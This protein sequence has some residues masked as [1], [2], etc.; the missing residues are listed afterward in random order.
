MRPRWFRLASIAWLGLNGSVLAQTAPFAAISGRV[1]D[2]SGAT[3]AGVRVAVTSPS[4]QGVREG[5][6]NATGDFLVPLLPP[7]EYE[8]GFRRDGFSETRLRLSLHATETSRVEVEL[9]IA[10]TA[11][12]L[13]VL[14]EPST[15]IGQAAATSSAYAA[16]L[17]DRLPVDRSPRGATLLAPGVAATA[18]GDNVTIAGAMSYENLYLVDGVSV[19]ERVLGQPRPFPIEDAL[20][21]TS[22]LVTGISAEYGR[23]TGGVVNV[24]TRSGGNE[25]NG[26]F[27]VSL[28]NEA[29][30]S[31]T[32]YEES[33]AE[34]PREDS[35]EPTYEGT[36]GGAFVRDR[37]WYFLAGRAQ[38]TTSAETLAFTDLP[39]RYRN[40]ESRLEA[41]L[42]LS[43]RPGQSLRLAYGEIDT[44]EVNFVLAPAMDFASLG[45]VSTPEDLLSLHYGAAVG[46]H[47]FLEG[48]YSR[49]RGAP[50]GRGSRETDLVGGTRLVDGS[51]GAAWNSPAFC[52]VC[53]AAPGE[54]RREEQSDRGFVAKATGL[55]SGTRTGSHTLVLG[56]EVF[57]E[58][59][60]SNSFQSGSGFVVTAS[61][62]RLEGGTIRPVFLPG[63]TT[64][65]EWRPIFELS[66]GSRFRTRSAFANDSWRFGERWSFNLGLRWDADDS[67]DQSGA[68]V[69]GSDLWSP[70]LAAAFDPRGDGRWTIDAGFARYA[71]SLTFSIGDLGTGAGRPARFAYVYDGP[72]VNQDPNGDPVSTEEALATLFDW[73]FANGGT[74]RPL[75]GAPGIPGLNRRVDRDLVLPRTDETT[76]G[77]TGRLGLGFLRLA[78]VRRRTSD[79]Y[80]ERV[81]ASTGRVTDP[82]SGS[83]YDLR[84]IGNGRRVERAYNAL[85]AQL[86]LQLGP[87]LRV[88]G[89]Y[90]YAS[91]RGNFDGDDATSLGGATPETDL[92][93]FPEYGDERWRAP[94]GPLESDQRHRARLWLSYEFPLR[95][96][97]ESGGAR[98]RLS[99]AALERVESGLAWGAVGMIDTRPYVAN[100]GYVGPPARVPYY[101]ERRGSRR[102]ETAIATDVALHFTI[103]PPALRGAELFA[104][105]VVVNLLDQSAQV[106][107]GNTTVLTAANDARYAPFDPFVETPVRGVH[108]DLAPGFGSALGSGD[109]APPRTLTAALGVRF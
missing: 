7:G 22:I 42:T 82:A 35:V 88:A 27:R 99:I 49:R 56:G 40:R 44:R 4:L 87:S 83:L 96:R 106:R 8:I 17:I 86:D 84:L 94:S 98:S 63:G 46:R 20:E 77:V 43:P 9:E 101:F 14:A 79:Q 65:I 70:R 68:E 28:Q 19:K 38:E 34:D 76:L 85:L 13:T 12:T 59:R 102:T 50:T 108:W 67:R 91:T 16:R 80:S 51:R 109:F 104:R 92:A 54:L 100:P 103:S 32:R 5:E 3:V 48:Q 1:I 61:G 57:D 2:P 75:R 66:R 39:Y 29:W 6:T 107:P 73:F 52:A 89:S 105:V 21:E 55:F 58:T 78:G 45:R 74:S 15:V 11:D 33:L 26:S 97:S 95:G 72:A 69:T 10:A 37:L 53:G 30:R 18:P 47:L 93:F 60:Q 41:K 81:D 36:L 25:P 62:A 31:A 64:V 90:T 71:T 23:F 24:V